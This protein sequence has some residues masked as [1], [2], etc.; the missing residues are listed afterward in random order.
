MKIVHCAGH[1]LTTPGK[2]TP[3]GMKEFEFNVAVCNYVIQALKQYEG[4]ENIIVHDPTGKRDVPLKERTDKANKLK[5]DLYISYH[6]NAAGNSWSSAE[7]IE[8]YIISMK[9]KALE[10]A[11][12]IHNHLL[13]DTGRKNRGLKTANF[14]VLRETN[15]PAILFELGFMTNK[16][17][18]VLLKSDSYRQKCAQAIV[19]GLVEYYKL[20]PKKV[21][22][23]QLY[24][25]QIGAFSDKANADKLAA[26]LNK[27]GY[28]AIV[29]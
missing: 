9:S 22:T 28:K 26:E 24:T 23:S 16:E 11:S 18:A 25:V 15:M 14:H 3:D 17:E 6:A 1:G 20:K 19:K 13:R 12:I 27:K 2:Q 4:V 8:T 5:A 7:G 21:A 29:K 10:P